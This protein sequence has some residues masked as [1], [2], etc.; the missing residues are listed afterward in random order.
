MSPTV[1]AGIAAAV[2]FIEYAAFIHSG[3]LESESLERFSHAT[4]IALGLVYVPL[5]VRT[6]RSARGRLKAAWTAMAIGFVS[7]LLGEA[8]W[9]NYHLSA[10]QKFFHW[11]DVAYL[12][13]VPLVCVALLLFPTAR[14]WRSQ[15]QMILD[16]IIVSGS[17]FLI[18]WLTAMHSVWKGGAGD[19]R[20]LAVSLA[21]AAG[22][23]LV[24]TVGLLVLNRAAPELRLPLTLLVAGQMAA[25][26]ARLAAA[27]AAAGAAGGVAAVFV[28]R[29]DPVVVRE[30]P[31]VIT[32]LVLVVAVLLRQ[33]L[34]A[35]ELG[36]RERQIRMLAD[37]LSGELSSAG[38]YVVS[39]LPGDLDG[40]VRV[41]SRYLPARE[42]G[43]DS[44]GYVWVDDDHLI[45]Y[46][47]DVSGHGVES[48]L[49]SVSVHNML[50][51]RSMP[52]A[53]L[54]Y[55][56]QVMGQLN[57]LFGMDSH[58]DHY[59]TMWY[60][61]YQASTRL[62]RYAAAGHPPALA[63][64]D[65]DG[66]ITATPLGG[67]AI[68]VGMF[69]DTV[70]TVDTYRVPDR[71]QI[72]LTS[73]GVLGDRLSFASFTELCEEVAAEPGWTP[74]SVIARLRATAGGT[75]EDDCALVQLSF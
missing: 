64:T 69:T 31:A 17:F 15:V 39:I 50:R 67:A 7:W 26:L 3:R 42:I 52:A 35:A 75:F 47:I 73:D 53:T 30:S 57:Q 12:A 24:M 62:L 65:E 25:A 74:A 33:M 56:E 21:Y 1:R 40:R 4:F 46:L 41:R 28:V 9:G 66:V 29:A 16:G 51:S 68:P 43:G 14:S 20:D 19:N 71:A 8:L 70:F 36:K 13:Y 59:F 45:V 18:F 37:R 44:F 49:L 5:A 63:L 60:G 58:D 27:V 23:V 10:D 38:K 72:L 55:P 54:L 6:A 34:E 11:A 22:D 32:G 61:V 2:F 48:A